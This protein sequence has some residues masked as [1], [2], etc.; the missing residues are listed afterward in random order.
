MILTWRNICRLLLKICNNPGFPF[1]IPDA[2]PGEVPW[3]EM[4]GMQDKLMHTY[5]GVDTM[6]VWRAVVNR[7]PELRRE[8]RRILD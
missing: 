3:R 5:L 2:R 6:L 7:V 1:R 8:I 4:A